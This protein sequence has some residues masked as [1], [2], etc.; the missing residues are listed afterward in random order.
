MLWAPLACPVGGWGWWW[1]GASVGW[2]GLDV[3]PHTV[4]N[5]KFAC[6]SLDPR[7]DSSAV[8]CH[9]AAAL[10]SGDLVESHSSPFLA[11]QPCVCHF[12]SLSLS[13]L[14]SGVDLKRVL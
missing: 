4:L 12:S 1:S 14:Q 5:L 13:G 8:V 3:D 11:V 7:A 2:L 10:G 9:K 6:C